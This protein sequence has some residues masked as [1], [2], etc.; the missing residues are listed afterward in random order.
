[1]QI[2]EAEE[3]KYTFSNGDSITFYPNSLNQHSNANIPKSIDPQLTEILLDPSPIKSLHATLN[4]KKIFLGF[5]A[6]QPRSKIRFPIWISTKILFSSV[7]IGGSIG[8]GKSTL[9]ARLLAG[10]LNCGMTAII[11][12]A[13]GGLEI[14]PQSSAFSRLTLYLAQRL[15]LKD[16]YYRWPRG[17]CYFNP[18]LYLNNFSERKTFMNLIA[19]QSS[20]IGEM[21][22]YMN[23]AADMAAYIIELLE[24][25]ADHPMAKEKEKVLVREKI[26]LRQLIQY[27][28]HP[29]E[30]EEDIIKAMSDPVFS[31]AHSKIQNIRNELERLNFFE[32]T[33]AHGREKFV[34]TMNG[35]NFFTSL[36]DEEDLLYY[37]EPHTDD[38]E[39]NKLKKLELDDILYDRSLVVISQ[40]LASNHPSAKIVGPIFWDAL[41]N[42]T[43][44]IGLPDRISSDHKRQDLAIFLDET[45]RLPTGRVGE[46]S[47]FL[48]EYRVGIVEI[49]PAIIDQERWERSKHVYQTIISTSPGVSEVCD[50]MHNRLPSHIPKLEVGIDVN[51]TSNH[52]MSTNPMIINRQYESRNQDNPGVFPRSLRSTGR[53]TALLQTSDPEV[54]ANGLFWLD[55]ESPILAKLDNL[56]EEALQKKKG[57]AKLIDYALGLIQEYP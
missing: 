18:L 26:S 33:A 29:K 50:L 43:L 30:I 42:H 52:K 16:R 19:N 51:T 32:L 12:E 40:P 45:H 14:N 23:R 6:K 37:T 53:Y 1:M 57:A 41:L 10:S 20:V 48:R 9:I 38:R 13:K 56:L 11:G 17:N 34:M 55:L 2:A 31:F 36:L 28:K 27:L 39:G 4:G 47:D 5:G 24:S 46:S 54:N 49:T 44:K 35:I 25:M 8:S 21:E 7:L 3:Y 15:D 22:A